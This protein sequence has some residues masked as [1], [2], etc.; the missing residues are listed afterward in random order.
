MTTKLDFLKWVDVLVV[1]FVALGWSHPIWAQ[2]DTAD[3]DCQKQANGVTV[4]SAGDVMQAIADAMQRCMREKQLRQIG[5]NRGA[6]FACAE[7][8]DAKA[9]SDG[10]TAAQ[11]QQVYSICMG[12]H[13]YIAPEK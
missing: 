7:S 13:G 6:Q 12:G 1:V 4:K 11:R 3:R 9:Q 8:A 2:T 5:L 10:L